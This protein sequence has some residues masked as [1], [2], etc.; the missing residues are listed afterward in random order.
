[1]KEIVETL[2]IAIALV[3]FVVYLFLQDWRSTRLPMLGD[4][5]FA[6]RDSYALSGLRLLHQHAFDAGPGAGHRS[7]GGSR[8]RCCRAWRDLPVSGERHEST[9]GRRF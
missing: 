7:G 6:H 3:I 1:M 8:D 2:V 4:A 9:V 5:Y